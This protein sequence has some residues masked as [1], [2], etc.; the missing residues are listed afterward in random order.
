[1][2]DRELLREYIERHSEQ[3]FAELVARPVSLVY[4]TA[5]RLVGDPQ[6]AQ[7]VSGLLEWPAKLNL[8]DDR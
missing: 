4:S 5:L 2:E 8:P 3:A 6:M 7:D 1:M